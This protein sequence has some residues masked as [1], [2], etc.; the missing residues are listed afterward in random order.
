MMDYELVVAR[1]DALTLDFTSEDFLRWQWI[2]TTDMS[3]IADALQ[4]CDAY[5][6]LYPTTSMKLTGSYYAQWLDDPEIVRLLRTRCCICDAQF[7]TA[8]DMFYH[9]N[10]AHGCLP[11]CFC[12][13]STMASKPFNGTF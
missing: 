3:E 4:L 6:V 9:H 12:V 5:R 13:I 1:A 2:I 10:L 7:Q 11:Q 8:T